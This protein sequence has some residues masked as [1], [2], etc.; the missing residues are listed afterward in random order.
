MDHPHNARRAVQAGFAVQLDKTCITGAA[1][2]A[3]IRHLTQT[4][5][6]GDSAKHWLGLCNL[7]R[8]FCRQSMLSSHRADLWLNRSALVWRAV[9]AIV[10]RHELDAWMRLVGADLS[11]ATVFSVSRICSLR[12][13]LQMD[14]VAAAASTVVA[15]I[16]WL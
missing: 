14:T 15:L 8:F 12:S 16:V 4:K 2:A 7:W 10:H 1:T 11:V 13:E 3:A 6:Y 9:H 5:Q